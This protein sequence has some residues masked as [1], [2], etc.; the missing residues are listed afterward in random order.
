MNNDEPQLVQVTPSG[1]G[2][3][4]RLFKRLLDVTAILMAVPV[5]VPIVAVAAVLV[6]R[7][8]GSPFYTQM[9][10][11]RGGRRFRMWKLRSMVC[12]ADAR[13]ADYLA[14][15]P[16]ARQEWDS[17][18]KLKADPRITSFGKFLRKSSLDELPQLWNVLIGDMSLVGPRPMMVSQQGLYPGMAYYALRPGITGY[19]QT[20]GRNR[21]TFEARAEYDD[22]YEAELSLVADVKVLAATVGVV[23]HGTGY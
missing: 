23:V 10:V 6:A 5:V 13:M 8:G 14:S 16:V 9:R 18:Q 2:P 19:W 7:D 1:R 22:A 11:G 20:A 21:T 3:Y 12:D 17:T 4:R 15:D